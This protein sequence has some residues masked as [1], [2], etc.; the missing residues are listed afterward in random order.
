ML[1]LFR[2]LIC[3]VFVC[4]LI[5]GGFFWGGGCLVVCFFAT[6]P[7]GVAFLAC[8]RLVSFPLFPAIIFP[9]NQAPFIVVEC[10]S[11]RVVCVCVCSLKKQIDGCIWGYFADTKERGFVF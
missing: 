2:G 1:G 9:R 8:V 3:S 4:G 5:F 7:D 6:C 10:V 11:A